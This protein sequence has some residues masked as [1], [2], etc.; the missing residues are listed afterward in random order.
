MQE[1]SLIQVKTIGHIPRSVRSDLGE[2]VATE[3]RN[4]TY[5][6]LLGYARLHIFPIAILK[7][8]PRGGRKK[9]IVVIFF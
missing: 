3:F 4:T 9:H 1:V 8:S 2:V 5:H 6:G 7:C